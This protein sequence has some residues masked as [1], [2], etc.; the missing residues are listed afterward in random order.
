MSDTS[1]RHRWQVVGWRASGE[2]VADVADALA[3]G[4][5]LPATGVVDDA[6]NAHPD[7]APERRL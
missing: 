1:E 3:H 2:L 5:L 4:H 6:T 7:G